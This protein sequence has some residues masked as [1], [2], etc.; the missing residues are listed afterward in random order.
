MA[1]T[2]ASGRDKRET[3]TR[4]K[5]ALGGE[6]G[7]AAA[8]ELRALLER[9]LAPAAGSGGGEAAGEALEWCRCLLSGGEPWDG[10]VQAV[11]AYDPA[12]LCGLVWTAN[13]VAYRCRTC[14]ISPCMS[15]CAECFHQGEHAGHD[16]NMFRSQA[17]GACD[18]GDSNVMREAGFCK[19]HRI[20]SNSNVPC[21][22]KDLLMMS[23]LVL[24]QFIFSLIQHL[25]EGYNEPAL[26][27]P[28]EKD[29]HKI[30]QVLEPHVSFLEDLTKMGGAMRSVLTQV[31]TSQQF[32]KDLSSGVGENACAKKSHEK[33]LIALKGSGLAFPE[34]KL[35]CGMEEQGAGTSTLAVQGLAGATA[36]S[37]QGDSSDE[38]DQDGSQGVGKRKRVKLSSTT[39]GL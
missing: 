9:V 38:E 35:A 30:L 2:G 27:L 37:G 21:V 32:Y 29:L 19:R 8:G 14:G 4:L 15:L 12:T 22:P 34:D 28:S 6:N 1:G 31:L 33:Y 20:K 3:A 5:A 36:T 16:Y 10:F 25:R 7:A 24:P 11:R 39:K 13:F 23:E 17:G 18:C 26:D